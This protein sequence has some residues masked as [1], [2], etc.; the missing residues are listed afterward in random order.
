MRA[1]KW[2]RPKAGLENGLFW[3]IRDGV[4]SA[5]VMT[6][7]PQAAFAE[8]TCDRPTETVTERE[9]SVR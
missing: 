6:G 3:E 4:A 5:E 7:E 8:R 2:V 9:E 1:E